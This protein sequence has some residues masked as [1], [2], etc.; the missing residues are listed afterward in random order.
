MTWGPPRVSVQRECSRRGE[1]AVL[2]GCAAL[3]GGGLVG[4]RWIDPDLL[5]SLAGP[6]GLRFLDGRDHRDG[7]WLRVWGMRGLL[8]AWSGMGRPADTDTGVVVAAVRAGLNDPAWRVREMAVK[9]V[10]R[11]Q[12]DDLLAI[13]D[14]LQRD[15]V[16]RVAAAAQRALRH[17]AHR[18]G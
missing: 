15:P 16:P 2:A 8:W 14:R 12:V 3:A 5:L 7:Y 17:L 4:D 1:P 9:V 11:H 6:G 10:A 13:V 18:P